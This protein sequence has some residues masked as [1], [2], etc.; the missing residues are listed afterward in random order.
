MGGMVSSWITA[1]AR[2]GD[3]SGIAGR[4][5]HAVEPI[6]AGEVVAVKGGHI[7]TTAAVRA[8]PEPLPNSEIQITDDLHLAALT[9]AEYE[10]VMLFLNHTN[11]TSA[12]PATRSWSPCVPLRPGR[13]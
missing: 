12:S 10:P 13:S 7:L 1:K 8:L 5:L 6:A 9:D 11:P 4:G 2:K 3:S